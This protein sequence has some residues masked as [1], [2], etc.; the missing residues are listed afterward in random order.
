MNNMEKRKE[1]IAEVKRILKSKQEMNINELYLQIDEN[2]GYGK[3]AVDS[4]LE[5]LY[6]TNRIRFD[7]ALNSIIW[8]GEKLEK[9]KEER[10][11]VDIENL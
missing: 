2:Y 5:N 9:K 7:K 4:Y 10:K 11:K 8:I 1:M 6:L 3:R